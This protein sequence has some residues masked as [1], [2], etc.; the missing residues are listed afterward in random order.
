MTDFPKVPLKLLSKIE[1]E[2]VDPS[3]M[4]SEKVSLHSI[5]GFDDGQ[6]PELINPSLIKSAKTRVSRDSVLI[7]LLNPRIS[8]VEKVCAG[9]YCF[10]EFAAV[11]PNQSLDI[12]FL[13]YALQTLEMQEWLVIHAEGSTRSRTRTNREYLRSG[14]IPLPDLETQRRI[15]DYLDRE[16]S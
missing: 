16:I 6:N 13:Y 7:S 9:S 8:R 1:R 11:T 5:P 4:G 10:P 14:T 15:A 12:S 3:E 2:N